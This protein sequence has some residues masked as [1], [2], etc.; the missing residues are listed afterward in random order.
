VTCKCSPGTLTKREKGGKR[1]KALLARSF[2]A[3]LSF[4]LIVVQVLGSN[5]LMREVGIGR[6]SDVAFLTPFEVCDA[7]S[8]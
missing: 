7:K 2:F 8:W 6:A 4:S 1:Y 5:A 3:A